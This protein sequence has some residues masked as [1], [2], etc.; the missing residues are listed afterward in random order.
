MQTLKTHKTKQYLV[1]I[2]NFWR[3][4]ELKKMHTV[5]HSILNNLEKYKNTE[6]IKH[7][8]HY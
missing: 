6:K 3:K 8:M 7:F 4:Y 5:I 2:I 1:I